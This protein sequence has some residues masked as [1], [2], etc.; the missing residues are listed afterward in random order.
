L[1]RDLG[2]TFVYVTHDQG[3]ALSMSHRVAVMDKGVV[4]QLGAPEE[5]YFAPRDEFVARFIGKSN[6]LA[7]DVQAQPK[8][9]LAQL[10]G[11]E[12]PAPTATRT[13]RARMCLRFESVQ[14]S[15]RGRYDPQMPA[16]RGIDGLMRI[17][18]QVIDVL[19]LGNAQEVKVRCGEMELIAHVGAR[20]EAGYRSGQPV[21]V[22]FDPRDAI[23]FHD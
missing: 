19:F 23:L 17:A 13:G 5:L 1:Q 4:R 21:V 6:I 9:L 7:C 12:M 22:T 2:I 11:F 18:G 8:G 14:L 15:D 10:A 3:E 20:R 16:A